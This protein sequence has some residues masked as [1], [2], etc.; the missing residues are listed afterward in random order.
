MGLKSKTSAS[1]SFRGGVGWGGTDLTPLKTTCP[2]TVFFIKT[3][4]S[5]VQPL[6]LS[7]CP[8]RFLVCAVRPPP[9]PPSSFLK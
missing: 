9:P 5:H 3:V 6:V 8:P 2:F 7:C 1:V 4:A